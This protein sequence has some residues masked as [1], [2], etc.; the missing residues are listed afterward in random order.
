MNTIYWA[1]IGNLIILLYGC[2]MCGS[3]K[4]IIFYRQTYN[5]SRT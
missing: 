5:I 1:I 2:I 4:I 3:S